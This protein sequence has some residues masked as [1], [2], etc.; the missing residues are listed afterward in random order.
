KV[1]V[2]HNGVDVSRFPIRSSRENDAPI[3]IMVA[4]FSAEKDF[5]TLLQ[6]TSIIRG[7][8]PGFRLRLVGDGPE[9]ARVERL[10]DALQVADSVEFL[11]VRN[12]IV[13][14]LSSAAMF[15]LSTNTEGLSIS[16][17]EAMAAGLPVV[18]TDVGGN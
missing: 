5:D 16:L 15:V 14:Q 4:R 13:E 7:R 17:L 3:A 1:S 11:G 6:A 9:R 12:D 10:A 2:I 8:V 18:A